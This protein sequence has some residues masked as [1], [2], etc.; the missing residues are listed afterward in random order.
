MDPIKNVGEDMKAMCRAK[1]K[2]GAAIQ[3]HVFVGRC[4]ATK[5]FMGKLPGYG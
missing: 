2:L 5:L 4:L 3:C 1:F